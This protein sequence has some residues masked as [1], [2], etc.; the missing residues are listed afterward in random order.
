YYK[1]G[2][3]SYVADDIDSAIESF[4]KTK[5]FNPYHKN[6]DAKIDDL[7]ELKKLKKTNEELE[8][9]DSQY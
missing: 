1:K 9:Q 6:I 2:L 7:S 4:E 5:E 8:R 3:R